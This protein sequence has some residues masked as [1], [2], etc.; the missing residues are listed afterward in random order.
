VGGGG[1]DDISSNGDEDD[2]GGVEEVSGVEV[3][4][5]SGIS[6]NDV[7]DDSCGVEEMPEEELRS[8]GLHGEVLVEDRGI[9]RRGA[10]PVEVESEGEVEV[11]SDSGEDEEEEKSLTLKMREAIEAAQTRAGRGSRLYK[12]AVE[13]VAGGLARTLRASRRKAAMK[14][15]RF[16]LR[17]EPA[18]RWGAVGDGM[19]EL[20]RVLGGDVMDSIQDAVTPT[21]PP[22]E[23]DECEATGAIHDIARSAW[24]REKERHTREPFRAGCK[25][26]V[27]VEWDKDMKP[28]PRA[29]VVLRFG[30]GVQVMGMSFADKVR[31]GKLMRKEVRMDSLEPVDGTGADVVT[32][33]N[34]A[35]HP[36]TLKDRLVHDL[37]AVNARMRR[38][39]GNLQY[40]RAIDA[41]QFGASVAAKLD[42]LSAFKHCAL[43]KSDA[44][45]MV[46]ELGGTLWRWKAM[47]FGS[48]ASPALFQR[49]LQPMIDSLRKRGVMLVVYV[50]DI[51]LVG[52]SEEDLA[53]A[54]KMSL[55]A[56][57]ENG[58]YAALDKAFITPCRKLVFLGLVVDLKAKTLRVSKRLA[59]KLEALCKE[60]GRWQSVSLT[61]LQRVGGLLAF[62]AQAAPEAGLWRNGINA[63]MGEAQRLPG[64][65]VGVKGALRDELRLWAAEAKHLP[66][67]VQP[68]D[69]QV[70]A[71][72][73]VTDAAG[74][75]YRGWG[76]LAWPGR[77]SAPDIDQLL[78]RREA[79]GVEDWKVESG[80][81]V[82]HGKLL[83]CTSSAA[84]ELQALLRALVTL[85]RRNPGAIEGRRVVWYG[86]ATAAVH[87]LKNWRSR[88]EGSVRWVR[89]ILQFCRRRR[90]RLEPH[91]VSRWLE[92]QPAADFLSRVRYMRD[93][94]EWALPE[95]VRRRVVEWAGWTPDIDLFAAEG[96]AARPAACSR[97]PTK[98]FRTD[99]FSFSWVGIGAWAFPP[100]KMVAKVWTHARG[101]AGSRLLIIVPEDS[102]VPSDLGPVR[103]MTL[104]DVSLV[105]IDG[106]TADAAC[107][108]RLT[109]LDV[110]PL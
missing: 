4:A 98:G 108:R 35:V 52:R 75:P 5:V 34:I 88:S 22:G 90:C 59:S 21:E 109:A 9:P 103:R 76:A 16:P 92:W 79:F 43:T 32:P 25:G 28:A 3:G 40:E 110:G 18:G 70:G 61:S 30:G 60:I 54:I 15:E 82:M 62:C 74:D 36:A 57:A 33:A 87:A 80:V 42:V 68:A 77:E 44:R 7:T 47:P 12:L 64:C 24:M 46:F 38:I 56:M 13:V 31:W 73:M 14:P 2:A 67:L 72:V 19:G 81:S 58:W 53:V 96:N 89:D 93:R 41:L 1:R 37:R 63:A 27:V 20:R 94:A 78:G 29:G 102:L 85:H 8:L 97:Y 104:G 11:G 50:D 100:F 51:L 106:V 101:A 83:A 17:E 26:E 39:Y 107:P 84:Y 10:D 91:W 49:A 66:T 71:T 99:A 6:S 95:E 45:C 48:A 55:E 23:E 86:D 69:G 65:T 105:R